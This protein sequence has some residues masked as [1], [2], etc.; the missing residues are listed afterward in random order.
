VT[1][2]WHPETIP[3]G[4][5]AEITDILPVSDEPIV[6]TLQPFHIWNEQFISDRLKWKPRQPL[7]TAAYKLGKVQ[8]IP[9]RSQNMGLQVMD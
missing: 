5:W 4:S 7:Y 9:F 3:I 2:G 6:R 1:S 8:I